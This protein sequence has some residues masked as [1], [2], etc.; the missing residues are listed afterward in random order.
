[1]GGGMLRVTALLHDV[2]VRIGVEREKIERHESLKKKK[3]PETLN[4][5]YPSLGHNFHLQ[6]SLQ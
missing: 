3:H 1:M 5:Y 4:I 6:S 2:N